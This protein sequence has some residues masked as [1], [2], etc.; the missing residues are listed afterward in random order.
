MT[1]THSPTPTQFSWL[2]K[3]PLCL[4]R[5]H[6]YSH[7]FCYICGYFLR[8]Q[9]GF[10]VCDKEVEGTWEWIY[11]D[12]M[13]FKLPHSIRAWRADHGPYNII[14]TSRGKNVETH[15]KEYLTHFKVAYSCLGLIGGT[16]MGI[17]LVD[18]WCPWG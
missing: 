5:I 2:R 14:A 3:V 16:N 15:L 11:G 8:L 10:T 4:P 1:D 7:L 13:W 12:S 18:G 6:V 9:S 17:I